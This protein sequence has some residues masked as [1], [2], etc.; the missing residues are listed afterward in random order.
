MAET[1]DQK[2]PGPERCAP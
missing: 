1:L 2:V